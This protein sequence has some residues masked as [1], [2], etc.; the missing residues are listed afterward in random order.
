MRFSTEPSDVLGS[1]SMPGAEWFPGATLSYA[2]HVFRDKDPFGVALRHASE[3]RPLGEW[4]WGELR[5]QTAAIA[6]GLRAAGVGRGDRVAAYLPNIPETVAAFLATASIG[7]VWSSAAPEFGARSVIDRFSQI[8]PKVLLAIDGYRYGGK[9]FDR[10]AQVEEI[11][12]EVAT[13]VVRL[14]YSTARGGTS[15]V[16]FTTPVERYEGV[17]MPTTMFC[18]WILPNKYSIAFSTQ[19]Q[20]LVSG[21]TSRAW[22]PLP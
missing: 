7:A 5:S 13:R 15:S 14:G 4:T 10:R 1:R 16:I 12:A 21:A 18:F 3:L 8:E 19:A 11:A 9:D 20:Y 6:S 2:E 17:S 22:L